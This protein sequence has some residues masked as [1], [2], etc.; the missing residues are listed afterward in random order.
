MV[1]GR[2]D[3]APPNDWG[4]DCETNHDNDGVDDAIDNCPDFPNT[5]QVN[6]DDD[7]AQ[8]EDCPTCGGDLCDPDGA[9]A[10]YAG[11]VITQTGPSLLQRAAMAGG[12]PNE[13]PLE[14]VFHAATAIDRGAVFVFGGYALNR[15]GMVFAATSAVDD[16][17]F[18]GA[19]VIALSGPSASPTATF[20]RLDADDAWERPAFH[21]VT[22]LDDPFD[23]RADH[24]VLIAG[25][26]IAGVLPPPGNGADRTMA[27]G[28]SRLVTIARGGQ[29]GVYQATDNEDLAAQDRGLNIARFGH[30]AT[31]LQDGRVL[32]VGGIY[33]PPSTDSG[34]LREKMVPQW[35]AE[36]FNPI[37]PAFDVATATAGVSAACPISGEMVGLEPLV[38]QEGDGGDADTDA[39]TDVDSDSDSDTDA[40]TD[41]DADTDADADA[42]ADAP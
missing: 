35:Q 20:T 7:G 14:S 1:D 34:P 27:L 9:G 13:L 40:D 17:L 19:Y 26:A 2:V 10:T 6:S 28:L 11:E 38:D 21:T 22:N 8:T 37:D 15:F 18:P 23:G 31:R 39:D 42:D 41:S 29:E 32:V 36:L 3:V 4:D 16:N 30:T 12:A 24:R 33:A 5:D 25:G